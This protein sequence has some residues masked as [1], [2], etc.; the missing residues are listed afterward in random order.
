MLEIIEPS[1]LTTI[2]DAG[3]R[4]W[5]A[6]GVPISGP[7]D[8][9]AHRAANLLVGNPPETAAVE[10]GITSAM[11]YAHTDCLVAVAGCGYRLWVGKWQLPLWISV[12]VRAG[13]MISI[14]KT[15]DGNWA[16]LAVHGGIQTQPVLGSR[17]T[18]LRATLAGK[19]AHPLQAGELLPIGRTSAFLPGL[20]AR[21]LPTPLIK[22][23]AATT[24]RVVPG[25]QQD[26]FTAAALS[27]FYS[28]TYSISST[29]DRTGYRLI[30]PTLGRATNTEMI[31]EG[32]S[33]GCIQV[34]ADGQP[35]I[36]QADCPTAGGYPKIGS[37]IAADQPLLAQAPI[38][39]GK[40]RFMATS[41][42]AA[43][44]SYREMIRGLETQIQQAQPEDD[45]LWAGF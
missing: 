32:M 9:Y 13:S 16:T 39:S 15:G 35:I 19:P 37:V 30:G 40:I 11:L 38:G 18:T 26:A 23:S 41:V 2:Q 10:I 34:P 27:T 44:T 45:Y 31:S 8:A 20:A 14:E 1:L 33:R 24:L 21:K 5:Q 6:F 25:P 43:Q 29:S 17:A 4:G 28:A 42:E 22:Y 36:M 3:R 7:M 12:Y